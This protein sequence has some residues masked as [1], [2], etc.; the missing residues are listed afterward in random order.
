MPFWWSLS[1]QPGNFGM[2]GRIRTITRMP[3]ADKSRRVTEDFAAPPRRRAISGDAGPVLRQ[4]SPLPRSLP[5]SSDRRPVKL[6]GS[7]GR[8][9]PEDL[10][11][12]TAVLFPPLCAGRGGGRWAVGE[13][14][15][16]MAVLESDL[17]ALSAEARRRHPAVKDAAEHAILKVGSGI[18]WAPSIFLDDDLICLA[19]FILLF[20][21]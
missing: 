9:T 21:C 11:G 14:M 15:A 10:A 13:K 5:A 17:R 12:V 2:S 6:F 19:H 20:C 18:P 16:F 7:N 8:S 3:F 4:I 1:S